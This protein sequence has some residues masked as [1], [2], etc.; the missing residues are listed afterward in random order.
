M[1]IL[2]V[3]A[4]LAGTAI[5]SIQKGAYSRTA[6]IDISALSKACKLYRLDVGVFPSSLEGLYAKPA[7]VDSALWQGPYMEGTLRRDP[8][9]RPYK[10]SPGAN[11]DEVSIISGGPDGQLGTADDVPNN[12]TQ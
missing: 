12:S 8:W 1:T 3:L 10:Y 7:E 11:A 9:S 5:F 4:G 6:Q 2:V